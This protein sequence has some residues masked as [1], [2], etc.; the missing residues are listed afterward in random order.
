V[1]QYSKLESFGNNKKQ[2]GNACYLLISISFQELANQ[3]KQIER[4]YS[5]SQL[6]INKPK[7]RYKN[8]Y[9]CKC[10]LIWLHWLI[11]QQSNGLAIFLSHLLAERSYH[12]WRKCRFMAVVVV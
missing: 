9:S 3:Q 7:N 12:F 2:I 4:S 8:I 6:D 5:I 1:A 11:L 10:I